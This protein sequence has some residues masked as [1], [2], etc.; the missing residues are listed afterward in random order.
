MRGVCKYDGSPGN[1]FSEAPTKS[2]IGDDGIQTTCPFPSPQTASDPNI[3]STDLII[4]IGS[5]TVVND[6]VI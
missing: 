3:E 6:K 4:L 1:G 5:Y 2:F